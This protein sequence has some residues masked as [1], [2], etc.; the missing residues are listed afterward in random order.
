MMRYA[1]LAVLLPVLLS[2]C[3]TRRFTIE[4]DPPG[5]MV[6][7]NG[8]Q[9]GQTPVVGH[10]FV[11]YGT[12]KFTLVREGYETLTVEQCIDP[13]WYQYPGIDFFAEN[14]NPWRITDDRTFRYQLIPLRAVRHDEVLGRAAELRQ[15]GQ[16]IR[17][18]VQSNAPP[19]RRPSP[20]P[21]TET[22]VLPA[23]A[24]FPPVS[25]PPPVVPDR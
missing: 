7:V 9:V 16:A 4:S 12:Y 24:P 21:A 22:E 15:R 19:G 6:F 18:H 17:P 25:A 10:Y 20:P 8:E 5:A 23:P 11:Y 13:P 14:F 3:V 1:W 2:G